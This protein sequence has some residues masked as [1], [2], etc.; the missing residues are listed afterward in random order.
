MRS[1]LV[2]NAALMLVTAKNLKTDAQSF[3]GSWA[4]VAGVATFT[5]FA[6]L[7]VLVEAHALAFGPTRLDA[8]PDSRAG[9]YP[10]AAAVLLLNALQYYRTRKGEAPGAQAARALASQMSPRA[11]ARLLFGSVALFVVLGILAAPSR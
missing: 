2:L 9:I 8:V 1:P 4:T 5:Q 6:I 11:P 7:G 10:I 3:G